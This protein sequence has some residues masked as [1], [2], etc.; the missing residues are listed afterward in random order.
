MTTETREPARELVLPLTGE[1][2]DLAEATTTDLAEA[3]DRLAALDVELRAA[4]QAIA[5]ELAGRLDSANSRSERVGDWMLETNPPTSEEYLV[6][7]LR[8]RLTALVDDG[9]LD[10]V[11]LSRVIVTPAPKPPAARVD[12]REVNKLKKSTDRR[13]LAALTAARAIRNNSRTIKV[14]RL[15][16]DEPAGREG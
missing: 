9:T 6:D 16:P 15:T 10:P 7:V 3:V 8:D 11:V 4:R 13:V 14:A 1:V 5:D 12:K 2:I